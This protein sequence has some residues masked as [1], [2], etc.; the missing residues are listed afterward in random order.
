M[1]MDKNEKQT[2]ISN[3]GCVTINNNS[4]SSANGNIRR[5]SIPT[6]TSN[7]NIKRTKSGNITIRTTSSSSMDPNANVCNQTTHHTIT[8]IKVI[9]ASEKY[10]FAKKIS[11]TLMVFILIVIILFLIKR[12]FF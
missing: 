1:E 11:F 5:N 9:L 3:S 12:L 10:H 8:P 6:P 2:K 7:N 4:S